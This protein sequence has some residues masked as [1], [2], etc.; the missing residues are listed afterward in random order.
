[1]PISPSDFDYSFSKYSPGTFEFPPASTFAVGLGISAVFGLGFM[2]T[3]FPTP[4]LSL[5][6]RS[7]PS[8]SVV[9]GHIGSVALTGLRSVGAL[10][11][12]ATDAVL[13]SPIASCLSVSEDM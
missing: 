5:V 4:L 9:A 13:S 10:Y 3:R 1:M 2:A 11:M 12:N 6:A 7:V 8:V